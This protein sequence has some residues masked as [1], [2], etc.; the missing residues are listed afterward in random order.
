MTKPSKPPFNE[1]VMKMT[2]PFERPDAFN[3]QVAKPFQQLKNGL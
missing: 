3:K 2:K 1:Q